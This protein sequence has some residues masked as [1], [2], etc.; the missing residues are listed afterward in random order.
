MKNHDNKKIGKKAV[1]T[2]ANIARGVARRSV[3]ATSWMLIHQPKEPQDL[4]KRLQ[5]MK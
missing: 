4:A 1:R 2:M 5:E 3:N